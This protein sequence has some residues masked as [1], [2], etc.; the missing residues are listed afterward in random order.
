MAQH[1]FSTE[2]DQAKLSAEM[3]RRLE[4]APP[5]RPVRAIVLLE[6]GA[7]QVV[8]RSGDR[9]D[10]VRAVRAAAASAKLA[11][12]PILS[13]LGGRWLADEPD[14]LGSLAVEIPVAGLLALAQ[15]D[16]VKAILEDQRVT[17]LPRPKR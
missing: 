16:R 7:P 12:D 10:A 9:Q 13:E 5:G 6:T 15:S 3:R 17:V 14:A 11:L 1:A 8:P 2:P 4:R